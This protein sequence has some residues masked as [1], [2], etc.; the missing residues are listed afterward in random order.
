M[1][2]YKKKEYQIAIPNFYI[3]FFGIIKHLAGFSGR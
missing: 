2:R 1:Q 3:N